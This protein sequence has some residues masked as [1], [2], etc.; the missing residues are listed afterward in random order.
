MYWIFVVKIEFFNKY[1]LEHDEK[2]DEHLNLNYGDI[3]ISIDL[4]SL[5]FYLPTAM[6]IQF[7]DWL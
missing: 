6:H 5:S 7:V 3:Q 4:P 1:G 2:S